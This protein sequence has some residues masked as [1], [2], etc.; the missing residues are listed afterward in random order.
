M[1]EICLF[2]ALCWL[3]LNLP[4]PQWWSWASSISLVFESVTLTSALM[5]CRSLLVR[6]D[7][8]R[9]F[10][11][12]VLNTLFLP[13]AVVTMGTAVSQT[14]VTTVNVVG[15]GRSPIGGKFGLGIR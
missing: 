12:G 15:V 5:D 9:V 8:F 10:S 2:T 7:W 3:G 4:L 1:S 11:S 6:S 13:T 14:G